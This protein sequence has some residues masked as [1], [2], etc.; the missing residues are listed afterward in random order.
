MGQD[1][2]TMNQSNDT[3]YHRVEFSAG[4]MAIA[5]FASLVLYAFAA[6]PSAEPI[7]VIVLPE[8]RP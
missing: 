3:L 8:V 7:Q 6:A 5:L 2:K 1:M 4:L